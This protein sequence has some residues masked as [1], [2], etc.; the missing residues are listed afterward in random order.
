MRTSCGLSLLLSTA[1]LFSCSEPISERA[2]AL[3]GWQAWHDQ[4]VADL[5]GDAGWLDLTGLHWLRLEEDSEGRQRGTVSVGPGTENLVVLEP[6]P[7]LEGAPATLAEFEIDPP[8][9]FE[10]VAA[11]GAGLSL[12]GVSLPENQSRSLW[13]EDSE[14]ASMKRLAEVR[15]GPLAMTLIVRGGNWAVRVRDRS[16]DS[17]AL[18]GDLD[19]WPA[20]EEWVI[21]ARFEA[22]EDVRDVEVPNVTPFEYDQKSV[23]EIVLTL[24]GEN[25]ERRLLALG[26]SLEEP[27]FLIVADETNG[28]ST[29]G[30]GRY[31]YPEPPDADGNLW[32]DFNRLYNPPCAFTGW[33]TC[34]LP[35]RQNRVDV[36]IEAGE[37][38]WDHPY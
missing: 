34:P 22:F 15:R 18:L 37:K 19:V 17:E 35:P 38:A 10:I 2:L 31:M 14:D 13:L 11:P 28:R 8:D 33:A 3:D 27:L 26:T 4:R 21:P 16:I 32:V 1:L 25:E 23:G 20:S 12:E 24:P 30:G 9:R 7:S 6:R 36:A 5:L 29:Y